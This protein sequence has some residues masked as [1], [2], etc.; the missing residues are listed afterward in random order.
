MLDTEDQL[1]RLRKRIS[2]IEQRSA[3]GPVAPPIQ[4]VRFEECI[5]GQVVSTPHGQ[6][7]ETEQFFPGHR[8][9]GSADV[10]ALCELPT[11][12]LDSIGSGAIPP[13]ATRRWAFLDTETTGLA[14]GSGTYAF[15]IGVGRI[16]DR[17]FHVRQFFMRDYAEERSTLLALEQ[18]LAEFDVLITYNGRTYDQPLLETR[19]RMMRQQP[20][21]ERLAHLDLLYGARRLWKLRLEGCKLTGLEEKILGYQREGDVPGHLIPHIYFE[22]LRGGDASNLMPVLHHNALDILTLACLT[23]I[24]PAAF[25]AKDGDALARAGVRHG[26]D[27]VGIA[28]WLVTE[29]EHEGALTLF[30]R[31]VDTGLPDSLLFRCLWDIAQLEKKLGRINAALERWTEL[32]GCRNDFRVCAFEELAK[33]YEHREKNYA[34]ALDFTCEAL[35][36]SRS[37]ELE[38]RKA[39]LELRAQRRTTKRLLLY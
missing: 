7:F 1:A 34:L 3:R 36:Y 11:D 39:R 16:T 28:R 9:H 20:P 18:H 4:R 35:R 33:Y 26:A 24:V 5:S 13:C 38:N 19:F 30:K 8:P 29:D 32:A 14:G 21:F 15:L 23:A 22:F 27:L 37:P 31:A 6:H 10:G 12:F 25:R 2:V 17:G